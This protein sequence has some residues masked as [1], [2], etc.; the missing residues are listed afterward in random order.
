LPLAAV[1]LYGLELSFQLF[2][3][4]ITLGN[5]GTAR[6]ADPHSIIRQRVPWLMQM[7]YQRDITQLHLANFNEHGDVAELEKYV[8]SNAHWIKL[9]MEEGAFN[10]QINII[11][12]LKRRAAAV[13]LKSEAN[14]L[15][16]RDDRFNP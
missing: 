3:A 6:L 5:F 9:H 7:R 10:D 12:F 15:I 8:Q 14:R 16:P 11:Y 4:S 2:C 1:A 13:Q